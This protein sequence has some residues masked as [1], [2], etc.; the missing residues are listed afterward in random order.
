M[1]SLSQIQLLENK[2]EKT[3]KKII[4]LQSE[5]A[6]LAKKC[7]SY[8]KTNA[9]LTQRLAVFEENQGAIEKGIVHALERLNSVENS[10]LQVTTT[11]LKDTQ[12]IKNHEETSGLA[13]AESILEEETLQNTDAEVATDS[14]TPIE[15]KES[16]PREDSLDTLQNSNKE[17]SE[18]A[19]DE[20]KQQQFDI[21]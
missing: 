14:F 21:F 9:E 10:V 19:V 20:K 4:S 3:L 15:E 16:V 18:E 1:I 5:N 17:T 13:K 2:I 7:A 12:D 11:E 8:E 6:E